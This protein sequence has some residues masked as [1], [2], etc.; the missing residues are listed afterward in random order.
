MVNGM[1]RLIEKALTKGGWID[2][3]S[4]TNN[5]HYT[6]INEQIQIY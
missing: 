3:K 6:P 5:E 1:K 4:T 2:Q